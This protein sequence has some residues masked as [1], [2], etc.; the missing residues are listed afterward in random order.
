MIKPVTSDLQVKALREQV[1][2]DSSVPSYIHS[3]HLHLATGGSG[4]PMTTDGRGSLRHLLVKLD[5]GLDERT[6]SVTSDA[7]QR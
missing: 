4:R 7:T 6:F 3:E 2:K 5:A 1:E